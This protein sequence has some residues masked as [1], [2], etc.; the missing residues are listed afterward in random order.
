V[1][2]EVW[3]DRR[4]GVCG[5]TWTGLYSD[6]PEW[7]WWCDRAHERMITEQRKL[8]LWPSMPER[9]PRYDEL[10]DVG[11]AV[12]DR[13]RG[14]TPGHDSVIGWVRRLR[15]AV[16]AELITEHEAEA[17]MRRVTRHVRTDL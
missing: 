7:C 16:E 9:G 8:L 15:V 4:C 17:A 13:T 2:T 1:V 10:D 6:D 12:W 5:A 14:Q 3:V 11:K